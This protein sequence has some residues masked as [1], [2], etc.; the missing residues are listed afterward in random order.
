MA[1]HTTFEERQQ[2]IDLARQ[3]WSTQ[4]IARHLQV[5]SSTVR[6]WRRRYREQGEEGLKSSMGRPKKGPL[7]TFPEVVTQLLRTLR[8]AHPGWG[9]I[10]LLA[11]LR[12][13]PE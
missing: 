2:M 6:K 7:S 1:K 9:P 12:R 8:H 11:A 4:Q 13:D 3:G 10:S 5:A